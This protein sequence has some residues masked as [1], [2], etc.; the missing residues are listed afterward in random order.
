M[1][2][3]YPMTKPILAALMTLPLAACISFGAEPPPSLLTLTPAA[4]VVAGQSQ[5]ASA[6]RSITIAVPVV[7]QEIS[8]ARV[9]VQATATTVAYVKDAQWVE[10]PARLFARLMSDT[11]TQQ[12]GRIVLDPGQFALNPGVRLTGELRQFGMDAPTS[13]AVVIYDAALARAENQVEKRRFE[14]R[15]PVTAIDAATVGPAINQAANQVAADVATWVG[16]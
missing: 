4:P 3:P 12:T 11:I 6:E 16:R 9:P 5:Q 7:P 8:S 13:S 14:A 2:G 15:V 1:K 10:A